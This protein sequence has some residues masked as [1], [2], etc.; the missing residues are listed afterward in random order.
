MR[1]VILSAFL[2]AVTAVVL[3]P[4]A[5]ADQHQSSCPNG[6]TAYAVPQTEAALRQFPRIA[7]GLDATPAPYTVQELIDLGNLIDGNDDGTFCLKAVSN[8]RGSSDKNWG[9]FYGA[10]DNDS[11]AS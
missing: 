2:F 6:Y 5:A 1:Q 11:A 3:V 10:R 8:L 4:G 7:A 9:Y